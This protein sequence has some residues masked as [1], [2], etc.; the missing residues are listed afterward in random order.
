MNNNNNNDNNN[1]NNTTNSNS[2]TG[3]NT[4]RLKQISLTTIQARS[5]SISAISDEK[6]MGAIGN[7]NGNK[8]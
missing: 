4:P 8:K 7:A 6:E 3:S 5:K 1:S 2:S